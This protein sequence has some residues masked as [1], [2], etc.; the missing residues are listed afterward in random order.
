MAFHSWTKSQVRA[1]SHPNILSATVWL[2]KLYHVKNG[3]QEKTDGVDLDTPLTY[4]DRFRI[5]RPGVQ[6][7]VHPP[8]VDGEPV[9]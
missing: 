3:D 5:R 9:C 8:H 7:D 1:R 6:W 4:A 2:N